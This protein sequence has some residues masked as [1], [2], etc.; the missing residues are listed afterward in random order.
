M[1]F[2]SYGTSYQTPLSD[3]DLAILFQKDMRPS[4]E[5]V[6][7]LEI[8]IS[9]IC[10]EDD[11]N[12]LSLND[13]NVMLQ[14]RVLDG[15]TS[16]YERDPIAVCDFREHVFKVYG[17]FEPFY[18]HFARQYDGVLREAYSRDRS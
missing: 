10:H 15:A 14:F 13:A 11:I 7:E 16:I 12:V 3:V 17:D 4:Q 1:V 9:D 5:R 8:S 18:R 2:G 6:I